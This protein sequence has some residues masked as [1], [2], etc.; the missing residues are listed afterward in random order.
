MFILNKMTLIMTLESFLLAVTD[1]VPAPLR[2]VKQETVMFIA[3]KMIVTIT[4]TLIMTLESFLLAMTDHVPAP[5]RLVKQET[6]IVFCLLPDIYLWLTMTLK[7][8]LFQ[9]L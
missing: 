1:L 2:L 3:N 9:L 7:S 6:V 4:L 5:L 8:F